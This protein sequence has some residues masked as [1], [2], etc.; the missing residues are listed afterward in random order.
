MA[1]A[2]EQRKAYSTDFS[3]ARVLSEAAPPELFLSH[4]RNRRDTK[5]RGL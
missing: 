2:I 1:N 3:A 5:K 4:I